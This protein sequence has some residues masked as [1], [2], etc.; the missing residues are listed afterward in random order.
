MY[1]L[2]DSMYILFSQPLGIFIVLSAFMWISFEALSI[3][4][5]RCGNWRIARHGGVIMRRDGAAR[6]VELTGGDEVRADEL[7][8]ATGRV[9]RT[10]DLGLETVDTGAT[11]LAAG[12][13]LDQPFG[14]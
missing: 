10:G 2:S 12:E 6:V 9:P 11:P 4:P 8:V 3:T 14:C 13:F 7:L 5:A 1:M